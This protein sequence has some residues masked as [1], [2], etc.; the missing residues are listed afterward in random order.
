MVFHWRLSDSKSPQASRTL[1]SIPAVLNDAVVWIVSARAQTSKSF[2][3]SLVTVPKAPITIV[4]IVTF[5]FHYYYYY[6]LIFSFIYG[7][8]VGV[9]IPDLG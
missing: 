5:M 8:S 7:F 9:F 2:Y 6:Y 4:K 1:L 3:N